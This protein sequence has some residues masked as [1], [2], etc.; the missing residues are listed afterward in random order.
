M[1][2]TFV[3]PAVI[4]SWDAA[5]SL[6]FGSISCPHGVSCTYLQAMHDL[7]LFMAANLAC[8]PS[9][10]TEVSPSRLQPRFYRY[11]SCQVS[12]TDVFAALG[13]KERKYRVAARSI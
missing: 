12:L 3:Y 7:I 2:A 8:T 5:P 13:I 4:P 6:R 9:T 10:G 11:L 1:T